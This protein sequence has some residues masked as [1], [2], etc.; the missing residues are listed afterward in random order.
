MMEKKWWEKRA[1]P[2]DI[3][4]WEDPDMRL[5]SCCEKK[6]NNVD[7]APRPLASS[8]NIPCLWARGVKALTRE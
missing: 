3:R 2:R 4:G 1:N 5:L 6:K 8:I 7:A